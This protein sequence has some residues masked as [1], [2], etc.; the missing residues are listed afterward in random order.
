M[1]IKTGRYRLSLGFSLVELL[2]CLV[3]MGTLVLSITNL[4]IKGNSVS[5]SM[6]TRYRE[7]IEVQSLILDLQK[8]LQQ[9][10]YIS[11]NSHKYRLE[12]TTYDGVGNAKKKVYGICYAP[13][14][15]SSSDT[16]C[17]VSSA[18]NTTPYLKYSSDGGSTW[19]SPYRISFFNKYQLTG[20]PMFLFAQDANNCTRFTDTNNNGVWTLAADGAGSSYACGSFSTSNPILSKPSQA[21]KIVWSG[22]QF[23]ANITTEPVTRSLPS[24]IFMLAPQGLVVSNAS[25]VSPGVKDSPL[26]AS[27]VTNTANSLFGT[28]F[29]VRHALWDPARLRLLVVGHH[30]G[31][32]AAIFQMERNGVRIAPVYNIVDTTVQLDSV[33]LQEDG[34]TVLALDDSTKKIYWYSLSGNSTLNPMQ[35]LNLGNPSLGSPAL[36]SSTN[37]V[38][39]PAGMLYDPKYPGEVFVVGVDPADSAMKIFEINT[40]TGTLATT[41]LSG[42]KLALPA[43][44]DASHPPSGLSQEPTTGDFLVARNYVNGSSSSLN[45]D[46]YRITSGGSYSSFSVNTYDLGSTATTGTAGYWGLSYNA[47]SNH[48]FL[49]DSNAEK[50]YEVYPSVLISPRS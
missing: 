24:N 29:D 21:S 14:S 16:T 37:L 11:D 10:A 26:L 7:A 18:S 5:A 4:L 42:G 34:Q 28:N 50:V 13:S 17:G 43:A 30:N 20:T 8:E 19:G 31:G 9:G 15:V 49:T 27:F 47:H 22:F 46:I 32:G 44:F 2:V 45:I 39:S 1:N 6:D 12:Y 41:L 3:L 33:A 23:R 38:N 36:S 35:I 25:A 48:L 40:S